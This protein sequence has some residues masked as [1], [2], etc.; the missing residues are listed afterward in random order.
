MRHYIDVM[1]IIIYKDKGYKRFM[2]ISHLF[3][4]LLFVK[5]TRVILNR[6]GNDII[7]LTVI[8]ELIETDV[9]S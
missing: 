3:L 7:Q 4:A 9:E 1:I 2:L 5:R 6:S 8:V